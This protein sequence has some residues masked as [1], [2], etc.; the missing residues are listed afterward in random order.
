M[1]SFPSVTLFF[2]ATITTITIIITITITITTTI[3]IRRSRAGA[4][5]GICY[6][7]TS[8]MPIEMPTEKLLSALI[9]MPRLSPPSSCDALGP[10]TSSL[11]LMERAWV[12]HGTSSQR[13]RSGRAVEHQTRAAWAMDQ[14]HRGPE[15]DGA[16]CETE[17]EGAGP[18]GRPGQGSFSIFPCSFL[19]NRH[20]HI[21]TKSHTRAMRHQGAVDIT[22]VPRLSLLFSTAALGSALSHH[23]HLQE[24]HHHHHGG[25]HHHHHHHHHRRHHRHHHH[26]Q[27]HHH[28]RNHHGVEHL[29]AASGR[30]YSYPSKAAKRASSSTVGD[31]RVV[32]A[33]TC[34]CTSSEAPPR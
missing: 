16:L 20:L 8:S 1:Y 26:R 17:V 18:N 9:L 2:L 29:S 11:P 12:P 7:S 19:M 25:H 32:G 15:A 23:H 5:I 6:S 4:G 28:R 21:T 22:T 33:V 31:A 3:I 10:S 24:Q 27:R 34:P 14:S 13:P 30:A